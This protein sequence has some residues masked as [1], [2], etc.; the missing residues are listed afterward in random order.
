MGRVERCVGSK[1]NKKKAKSKPSGAN[2]AP[3]YGGLDDAEH[4]GRP[5]V[6]KQKAKIICLTL[7]G[8]NENIGHASS[9]LGW[10]T[11]KD[12]FSST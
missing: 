5:T 8:I 9:S 7:F 4:L 12:G 1:T 2:P 10:G 3:S 6:G 11:E